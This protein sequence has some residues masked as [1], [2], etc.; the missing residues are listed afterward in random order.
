MGTDRM[1]RVNELLR[2]EIAEAMYQL[3]KEDDFDFAAVTVTRVV[4]SPTLRE[5]RV[6]VSIR[7]HQGERD[8]L[9]QVLRRSRAAIQSRINRDLT[10]KYT[11]KLSFELDESV[12]KG[13]NVLHLLSQIAA[14]DAAQAAAGPAPEATAPGESED[15]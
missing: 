5:A 13:D 2:R 9:L 3:V 14:E 7:D 6:M 1:L 10:L 12:E 11:P 15:A 8:R 4:A